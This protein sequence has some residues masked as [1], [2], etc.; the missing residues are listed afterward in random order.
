VLV[1]TAAAPGEV[2]GV[3]AY[4]LTNRQPVAV[5]PPVEMPGPVTA[6]WSSG[7]RAVAV[8]FNLKTTSYEA[9]SLAVRCSH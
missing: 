6:M 3:Q 2:D 4:E 8:A 9:Y 5:S 1:T 7:P